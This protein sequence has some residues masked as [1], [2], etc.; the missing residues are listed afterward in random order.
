MLHV[1]LRICKIKQL[2]AHHWNKLKQ[3]KIDTNGN[4]ATL[5]IRRF[6]LK[7]TLRGLFCFRIKWTT[8]LERKEK[9]K[10]RARNKARNR[11]SKEV[12]NLAYAHAPQQWSIIIP[13]FVGPSCDF[14]LF[15]CLFVFLRGFLC[16]QDTLSS[17]G[18][19][20]SAKFA[21]SFLHAESSLVLDAPLSLPVQGDRETA[22]T[23]QTENKASFQYWHPI[24]RKI[25]P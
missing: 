19:S 23:G 20:A 6:F 7:K 13:S 8:E 18:P 9:R 11:F 24:S 1:T 14:F 15:V 3:I 25:R 5:K 2:I 16:S 4:L 21:R 12:R 22:S 17:S 10:K